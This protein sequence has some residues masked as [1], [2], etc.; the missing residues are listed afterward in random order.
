[1]ISRIILQNKKHKYVSK[2]QV[3]QYLTE[4]EKKNA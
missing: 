2:Q 4:A 3:H 1:M